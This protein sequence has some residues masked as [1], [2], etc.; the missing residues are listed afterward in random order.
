MPS[1]LPF[2]VGVS[3]YAHNERAERSGAMITRGSGGGRGAQEIG[4]LR[5]RRGDR[6]LLRR[7]LEAT[8]IQE[9]RERVLVAMR[10]SG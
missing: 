7:L 2:E 6:G 1:G 8:R 5:R 3:G 10:R 9:V 4:D